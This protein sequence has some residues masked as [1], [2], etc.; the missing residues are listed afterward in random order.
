MENL[1]EMQE[2]L[3]EKMIALLATG[4]V[5]GASLKNQPNNLI[6][7]K[8]LLTTNI[9]EL[10]KIVSLTQ[11]IYDRGKIIDQFPQHYLDLL[12][13]ITRGLSQIRKSQIKALSDLQNKMH[14]PSQATLKLT[15]PYA[16][17]NSKMT[18]HL[19]KD[20]L[21]LVKMTNEQK[22]N[23][24]K[25]LE[26]ELNELTQ[27]LRE[28]LERSNKLKSN[29]KTKEIKNKIKK[30]QK[31]LQKLMDQ[32]SRQTKSMPDEFLNP[33][34]F[35]R[36]N[37][38]KLSDALE[39]MQHMVSQGKLEEVMEELKKVEE[40]LKL[41]A[42]KIN[43]ADSEKESFLD[44]DTMKTINNSIQKLDQLENRQQKLAESATQMNQKLRQQQSKKFE[45]QIDKL[46]KDLL[47]DINS[48]LKI[49]KDDEHFLANH[50]TMIKMKSII[51]KE[52]QI[53]EQINQLSQKT[54]DASGSEKLDQNFTKLKQARSKL[55][56]LIEKKNSLRL[57]ES[58]KFKKALP[59]IQEKYNSLNRLAGLQ[60]LN[61]FADLFKQTYPN[62][63]RWQYRIRSAQNLRDDISNKLE[64]DLTQASQINNS[65]SKKLGSM[66]RSIRKNYNSSITMDQK[67]ELKQMEQKESQ[68]RKESQKLSERFN[69][70]SKKNP[71][72]PSELS[73][74]MKKTERHM[75]HAE[76]SLRAQDIN[77]SIESENQALKGLSETRD[78]LN[79]MKNSNGETRQA[80]RQSSRKLGT[81]SSPDSRRGGA[82]KMQ[83]ERVLLPDENQYKAPKEF[84]EEILNAMKKQAPKDYQRM[85]ME[86]Y[87]DLVQ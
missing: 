61:E 58:Q 1:V 18:E 10:I 29:Q 13:N 71:M 83:K 49:F 48:I 17:V 68:L 41:L 55:S 14:Q 32:L 77:K 42:N 7:W 51:E 3:T 84:R 11:K 57:N 62:I 20:I 2:E 72:I 69:E 87:K 33:N 46:F 76:T 23:R 25:T 8:Q 21:F 50:N 36:L 4:L 26:Q 59:G 64:R 44:P 66:V 39:K 80:K 54:V 70:L 47:L 82:S 86:Y 45:N 65:I 60:D 75:R 38:G 6:A 63:L 34:A 15:S 24:T 30:I 27:T 5:K 78:L 85:I 35:K 22:L 81:G 53:N 31:T 12:K 28:D 43:R 40:N 79:Q 67:K 52:A 56:Q 19:E 9:D 37:M 73:Q 16:I 74:G